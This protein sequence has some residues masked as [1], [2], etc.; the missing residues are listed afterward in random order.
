MSCG[1]C[2]VPSCSGSPCLGNPRLV[3]PGEPGDTSGAR[4]LAN[5]SCSLVESLGVVADSLRQIFTDVGL[6]PYRVHSVVYRWSGGEVGRGTATV[7]SDREF[8][9]TPKLNDTAGI[10]GELRS[11]GLV[12]RGTVRLEQI[13]PRYTE[14]EVRLLLHDYPLPRG[15][16]GFIEVR[17]DARDGSTERRRFIVRGVPYRDAQRFEWRAALLRQDADR[18]RSGAP[19]GPR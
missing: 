3:E 7:V 17:V 19:P 12:E 15:D 10:A 13:S 16:Q 6:R 8:L 11:S 5:P 4:P 2:A 9:P 14:D 18:A 1:G